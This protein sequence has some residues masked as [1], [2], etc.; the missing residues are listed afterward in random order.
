MSFR[1]QHQFGAKEGRPFPGGFS[2]G[3]FLATPRG[4]RRVDALHPGD[5]VV[6]RTG[7]LQRVCLIWKHDPVDDAGSGHLIRLRTRAVGPMMPARPATLAADQLILVPGYRIEGMGDTE[8][9]LV[10]ASEIAGAG[11]LAE[12][13]DPEPLFLPIL[14]EQHIM[15][16]DGLF[17]ASFR[18][19]PAQ[20]GALPEEQRAELLDAMPDLMQNPWASTPV[21][22]PHAKGIELTACFS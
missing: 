10:E 19:G 15:I 9:Q 14:S 2:R 13:A 5:L 1:S 12:I 17:A 16:A 18:P 21:N 8:A 20:V 6:T 7:G 22:F 11:G 3:T 4:P